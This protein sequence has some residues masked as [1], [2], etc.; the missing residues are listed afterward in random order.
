MSSVAVAAAALVTGSSPADQA[1]GATGSADPTGSQV[2][3][4]TGVEAAPAEPP[5]VT[6]TAATVMRG[7]HPAILAAQ[8]ATVLGLPQTVGTNPFQTVE[9]ASAERARLT[10]D[11]YHQPDALTPAQYRERNPD[12]I[13]VLPC[14][15]CGV[16]KRESLHPSPMASWCTECLDNLPGDKVTPSKKNA[17]AKAKA[18]PVQG[19]ATREATLIANQAREAAREAN[20]ASVVARVPVPGVGDAT[21]VQLPAIASVTPLGADSSEQ[22]G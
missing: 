12:P 1:S 7:D 13:R 18:G 19:P 16:C 20:R 17:K 6:P 15:K 8:P 2:F 10:A 5:R 3:V 4:F 21:S 14:P 9:D 11:P 22:L